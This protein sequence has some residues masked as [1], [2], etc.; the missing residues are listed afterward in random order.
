MGNCVDGLWLCFI[1]K[2]RQTF[3]LWR[4]LTTQTN[5]KSAKYSQV[6]L[7]SS[8][9]PDILH[10]YACK[11]VHHTT[12]STHTHTLTLVTILLRMNVC[13]CVFVFYMTGYVTVVVSSRKLF[14]YT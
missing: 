2:L 11:V 6:T 9:G 12:H 10:L 5:T 3:Q 1:M 13:V 7:V 8:N 4:V 14:L